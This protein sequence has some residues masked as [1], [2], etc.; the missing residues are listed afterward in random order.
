MDLIRLQGIIHLAV[1]VVERNGKLKK[2]DLPRL[3]Q[4]LLGNMMARQDGPTAAAIAYDIDPSDGSLIARIQ[5]GWY[6][7]EQNPPGPLGQGVEMS[8]DVVHRVH[9]IVGNDG[10]ALIRAKVHK[11]RWGD[12]AKKFPGRDA[13]SL[14]EDHEMLLRLID[15]SRSPVIIEFDEFLR[16][17]VVDVRE[18]VKLLK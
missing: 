3:S 15:A 16:D 6:P 11:K 17:N 14:K 18:G 4:V 8:H 12:V 10:Y 1:L 9:D 7:N 5:S 2:G 13:Q